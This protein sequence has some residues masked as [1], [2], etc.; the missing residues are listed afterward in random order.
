[1]AKLTDGS[2]NEVADGEISRRDPF[3]DDDFMSEDDF[4]VKDKRL[5]RNLADGCNLNN[6]FGQYDAEDWESLDRDRGANPQ[7][8]QNHRR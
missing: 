1:M 3:S 7:F 2:E 5:K 8:L 6:S 4:V